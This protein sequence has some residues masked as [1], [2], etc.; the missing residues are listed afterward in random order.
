MC[1]VEF[2]E[3]LLAGCM[4][5]CA[6]D[7]YYVV[8]AVGRRIENWLVLAHQ[9]EGDRGGNAPEGSGVRADVDE[10]P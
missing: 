1:A 6:I 9:C 8:A 5:V 2:L 10:V 7:G 3:A 4:E